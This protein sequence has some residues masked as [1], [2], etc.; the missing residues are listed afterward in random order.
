MRKWLVC[1]RLRKPAAGTAFC[2]EKLLTFDAGQATLCTQWKP[3]LSRTSNRNSAPTRHGQSVAWSKSTPYKPATNKRATP[4]A[5]TTAWASAAAMPTFWAASP[6]KST[7]VATSAPSKWPSFTKKCRDIGGKS[8]ASFPRTNCSKSPNELL[9]QCKWLVRNSA[10]HL[11]PQS[12][13]CWHAADCLLCFEFNECFWFLQIDYRQH[14]QLFDVCG[15]HVCHVY[16]VK[17]FYCILHRTNHQN[18]NQHSGAHHPARPGVETAI[19]LFIL[20][21]TLRKLDVYC[22]D[23]E[24]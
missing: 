22:K 5:T 3:K 16:A 4:P 24:H 12:D 2:A 18:R 21:L 10:T 14:R 17:H 6:S 23:N 9:W 15:V 1:N 8:W 11:W 19:S 13:C 20:T 7:Q